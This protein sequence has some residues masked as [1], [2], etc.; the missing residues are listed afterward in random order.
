MIKHNFLL[1]KEIKEK[2]VRGI[3]GLDRRERSLLDKT[4][5]EKLKKQLIGSAG[6][7]SGRAK[8]ALHG[9]KAGKDLDYKKLEGKSLADFFEDTLKGRLKRAR[10]PEEEISTIGE[11]LKEKRSEKVE[12]TLNL[13]EPLA[14]NPLF[15]TDFKRAKFD[16]LSELTGAANKLKDLRNHNID[17]DHISE[18]HLEEIDGLTQKEK[19][20]ILFTRDLSRISGTNIPVVE[21]LTKKRGMNSL[22]DLVSWEKS[23]WEEHLKKVD[24]LEVPEGEDS[25]DSYAERM[26][27]AV[28]QAYPTP[29]FMDRLVV[30][31]VDGD[32]SKRISEVSKLQKKTENNTPLI[33]NGKVNHT[34]IKE[35]GI[36]EDSN[37]YAELEELSRVVNT[38]KHLGV[39]EVLNDADLTIRDK[40]NEI[41]NRLSLLN[42]FYELNPH[43]DLE[44]GRFNKPNNPNTWGDLKPDE[45]TLIRK[46]MRALQRVHKLAGNTSTAK[47]LLATGYD[48][49]LSIAKADEDSFLASTGLTYAEG[50]LI[51]KQA[52]NLADKSLHYFEGIRDS[53]IGTFNDLAVNNQGQLVNDLKDIDGYD[54][55]FGSQDFCQCEHC[56][57]I[58]SAAAYFVD[59]MYFIHQNVSD[60]VFLPSLDDHPLYLKNRRPDL[61][62]L[63]LSC[64]NTNEL[65]PYL[66][67]VNEVLEAY[68]E[69]EENED[70]AY[71]LLSTAGN[72]LL[73]PFNLPLEELRIYL[74]YF[75]IGLNEIYELLGMDEDDIH[76]EVFSIS[77]QE[78]EIITTQANDGHAYFG[79]NSHFNSAVVTSFLKIASI[80]RDELDVFLE[81]DFIPALNGLKV[82]VKEQTNDDG[83]VIG[84]YEELT[85]ITATRLDLLHRYIRLCKKAP[86]TFRE[87]DYLLGFLKEKGIISNL[88]GQTGGQPKILRLAELYL[89]QEEYDLNLNQL[90]S[91]FCDM[92]DEAMEEGE[93]PFYEKVFDVE[94]LFEGNNTFT[95]LAD[96]N[97]DTKTPLLCSALGISESEFNLLIDRSV[98]HDLDHS[99]LS[100]L[101]RNVLFARKAG[102]S[103]EELTIAKSMMLPDDAIDDITPVNTLTNFKEWMDES[104]FSIGDMLFITEGEE[105]SEN[106]YEY[107]TDY[108][109]GIITDIQ[110]HS[111]IDDFIKELFNYSDEEYELIRDNLL[112]AFD[113]ETELEALQDD[114]DLE[115]NLGDHTAAISKL[116]D[117]LALYERIDLLFGTLEFDA[118]GYEFLQDNTDVFGINSLKMDNLTYSDIQHLVYYAERFED[119][120]EQ[121]T[122]HA[123]LLDYQDD[124][125]LADELLEDLAT[126]WDRPVSQLASLAAEIP[127]QAAAVS[128]AEILKERSD[129]CDQLA[130]EGVSLK[131]F[132]QLDYEE[133]KEVRDI[134][135]GSIASKYS[136]EDEREEVL[137]PYIDNINSIKRDALCAFIIGTQKYKFKDRSDLY[138]FFLLDVE[139]SGCFR[140][141]RVVC[142]NSSLQLYIHRCLMNLEQSDPLLNP[143][144]D[145]IQV[146]PKLIPADEWEWRKNYRVWEA[147]R[148]VFL[149]PEN[150][151][152]P[153]LR[154]NKTH[155]FEELEDELL[156]ENISTEA[157]EMAYKKYV[158]GFN[159]LSRLR[160]AGAYYDSISSGSSYY[161]LSDGL[162]VSDTSGF[163]F[164]DGIFGS[165]ESEDSQYYLFARTNTDPY[166]YYYRTYNHY[167]RVWGNWIKID[168]GIEASEVSVAKHLG[169]LYIF[170]TEVVSKEVSSFD[171]GN[172][173]SNGFVFNTTVKYSFLKEDGEWSSPQAVDMGH[174]RTGQNKIFERILNEIPSNQ[175]EKDKLKESVLKRFEEE[176]FRKPY[177]IL[178]NNNTYPFRSYH[179]WSHLYEE[180]EDIQ[181]TTDSYDLYFDYALDILGFEVGLKIW[182]DIASTSFT[183]TDGDYSNLP[184]VYVSGSYEIEPFGITGSFSSYVDLTYY[185]GNQFILNE[186]FGV[187]VHI[188]LGLGSVDLPL[189]IPS[190]YIVD[191]TAEEISPDMK[192][193]YHNLSLSK[194]KYLNKSDEHFNR[195]SLSNYG[196]TTESIFNFLSEE[197]DLIVQDE[198]SKTFYVENGSKDFTSSGRK[199]TQSQN[200][201]AH[202]SIP[203]FFGLMPQVPLTT[204]LQ[205]EFTD[206]LYN[207]GLEEFLSLQTQMLNDSSGSQIDLKGPYGEYYWEMFFHIPFLIGNHLNANQKFEEAKWWYERIFNPTAEQT[208]TD[209]DST[210]Y[211]WQFRA[212]RNMDIDSLEDVLNDENALEAYRE[213]P[214]DPHA[215]ARLRTSAYQKAIV[216]KYIDNL[217]DWGD[218]LFS[219]DTR[220]SITEANMI[221][222][223]AYDILGDRPAEL[224]ECESA[225]EED[226]TYDNI[227][228]DMDG[229][230]DFLITLE[231]EYLD[232][233]NRFKYDLKP[234][235]LSKYLV[236]AVERIDMQDSLTVRPALK[237]AA[238]HLKLS[239]YDVEI[240]RQE[241]G[242]AD[243]PD[244][245]I[246][247]IARENYKPVSRVP[248]YANTHMMYSYAAVNDAVY[249]GWKGNG[250]RLEV[251]EKLI[252]FDKSITPATSLVPQATLRHK[253]VL[254][255]CIPHNENLLDYWDRVEDRL[256][257]IRNCM[258]ISGTVRSLA[259]FQPPID[260]MMLVRAAAAGMSLNDILAMA[261]KVPLYRFN[262]LVEKAKE[263]TQNVIALG[264]ALLSALE[265]K[266]AEELRLLRSVHEQN[267]LNMTEK[268]KEKQIEEAEYTLE[269]TKE[270]KENVQNRIDYY[271]GLISTGLLPWEV[272]EQLSK[273]TATALVTAETVLR[274]T[275]GI[276]H[277]VPQVGAPTS[278]KYGGKELGDSQMAFSEFL[279]AMARI[280]NSVSA[281]AGLEARNQRRE[282]GW[283][284]Q[285]E[286]AKQEMKQIEEQE[287]AGEVRIAIAEKE[288]E[289]HQTNID[290]AEELHDFH[291]DKFT[292]LAL[293]DF[294]A[295][296]LNRLYRQ[297]YNL[298]LD[299]ARQAE[300]AYQFELNQTDYFIESDNWETSK[301]GLLSGQRLLFQLQSL[302]KN[303]MEKNERLP[304][305]TQTF[306]LSLLDP[307]KLVELKQTGSCTFEIPEMAFELVYPGMCR[308]MIRGV[309]LSVPCVVGPNTNVGAK[310][311]LVNSKIK[312]D[313]DAALTDH[314]VAKGDYMY[315]SGAQSDSGMFEFNFR[316]ERRLLFEG[317]GAISEW[318]LELPSTVRSFNYDTISDVMI[319]LSYSAVEG[320]RATA[321]QNLVSELTTYAQNE[322]LFRLVS[323]KHEF[324][325]ALHQL[326]NP[327]E[328]DA[329]TTTIELTDAHF[330][331]YL[332]DQSL[333][334]TS[335]EIYL[336]PIAGQSIGAP[337]PLNINETAVNW[338]HNQDIEH[339]GTSDASVGKLKYGSAAITD[340]PIDSWEI[341]A[342]SG[343]LDKDTVDDILMVLEYKVV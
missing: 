233:S 222:Q 256:F 331:Y 170:W 138:K 46:Q 245:P 243:I 300:Q 247:N 53:L 131:K 304:E 119:E 322:G 240:K 295:S 186:D 146:D 255:F 246:G 76:R 281:S 287:L 189:P 338:D 305:I 278:M 329:Q 293:Y 159:K 227:E 219:Q 169:R 36:K 92:P 179:V 117:H 224:G 241:N 88:E 323:M 43:L 166:E 134:V 292:G 82:E 104:S 116:A 52:V 175:D 107:T 29:Y 174:I 157:A 204:I 188:N 262:Y 142:A 254:A 215:I 191:A 213:D 218:Y 336:K 302:E 337:D 135:V 16:A 270:S 137:E 110:S 153:S 63:E 200:T 47:V 68:I 199:L 154:D 272:T 306:S 334:V 162:K 237:V 148:K 129:V 49:A 160:Y 39:E 19:T 113:Y 133:L 132:E 127:A 32:T 141:S 83:D 258:N 71:D 66:Q 330:P 264:N 59:L 297:A 143:D 182:V 112:D 183:V 217:L 211:M 70:D 172:S 229:T 301:A 231:N 294:L 58:F 7:V 340:D 203:G 91:L 316:D 308:R 261:D 223:L 196:Y 151:I 230:D 8:K 85:H 168:L 163:T 228:D 284:H 35:L 15:N 187:N 145:D 276:S 173:E 268:V 249:T 299:L 12:R 195:N 271:E 125:S 269:A 320:D 341:D 33:R 212:F 266:D 105:S 136:D 296:N 50:K 288:L 206:I 103:I 55:L 62:S 248:M 193:S 265:K 14:E 13:D 93:A 150:Y 108:V 313:K 155:L 339:T 326:L 311:T 164:L 94:R 24:E 328:G 37:E 285:L 106:L 5:N 321:E 44:T 327:E 161:S 239:D 235:Q 64:K 118:A 333:E 21:S 130:I 95:L 252:N 42:K 176:V 40:K 27:G 30:N 90:I 315:T 177:T 57:S 101:Y 28:E 291:E 307:A 18:S 86:W 144:Y 10:V 78:L 317:A 100:G 289:I 253:E 126:L 115:N 67:I 96:R 61:W 80:S 210:E 303:Y 1:K 81:S 149:Y 335:F 26:R 51:K 99:D 2:P 121:E 4:L 273:H 202:L 221:Y 226:L 73:M 251:D 207:E 158:K 114:E 309:Q 259:L 178:R 260:P 23:D 89:I 232:I 152:E 216:I 20:N 342:S 56:R 34:A 197:A 279:G 84:M 319:T 65:I 167:K 123:A 79:E 244:F 312:A 290:Q 282:E 283:E 257:K 60:K 87:T 9:I 147:N 201:D 324:G 41:N 17:W 22:M 205:D 185:G 75:E 184:S 194:N 286:L 45:Q 109:E 310:L 3:R 332:K 124:S 298:A 238:N 190:T 156:Q 234:V 325:V 318:S 120:D 180:M 343:G 72:A 77:A 274:L 31:K 38:Y 48:S 250:I 171:D 314:S 275:A 220:E 6:R 198:E 280:A 74:T 98:D 139:M 140:T 11:K 25:V 165:D 111:H 102:W 263:F 209:Q 128:F 122:V 236:G 192:A 97:A 181:Y 54:A 242:G 267:I 214:F 277:L 69:E 225:D 208:S